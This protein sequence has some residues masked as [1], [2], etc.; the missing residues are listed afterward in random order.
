MCSKNTPKQY[1]R[2]LE[3]RGIEYLVCGR[4]KVDFHRALKILAD[5]H[6]IRT[7]RVDSGGRLNGVLLDAGLVHE[8][9]LLVHPCIVGGT[10]T[11]S[12]FQSAKIR[13][14]KHAIRLELI[15]RKNMDHG[16]EWLLYRVIRVEE[17]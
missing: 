8:V 1:L 13:S 15:R 10:S 7:L 4:E 2:Y 16:M 9:S 17:K 6:G 11:R 12:F 3:A 14:L 5:K